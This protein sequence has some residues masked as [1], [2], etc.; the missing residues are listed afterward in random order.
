MSTEEPTFIIPSTVNLSPKQLQ[1]LNENGV[2]Q[3]SAFSLT[4]D[5]TLAPPDAKR[6]KLKMSHTFASIANNSV[7]LI[8][9]NPGQYYLQFMYTAET[10]TDCV[11]YLSV[12]DQTTSNKIE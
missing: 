5:G 9:H 8:E 10:I 11:I 1:I 7:K 2:Q 6:Y 12:K 4:N 3:G